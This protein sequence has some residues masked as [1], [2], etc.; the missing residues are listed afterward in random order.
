MADGAEDDEVPDLEDDDGDEDPACDGADG[1]SV[2][3]RSAG[4]IP[5]VA[6]SFS[7]GTLAPTQQAAPTSTKRKSGGSASG[8]K[9]A[10]KGQEEAEQDGEMPE[11]E[12]WKMISADPFLTK[13]ARE[14]NCAFSCLVGLLPNRVFIDKQK[15]GHQVKGATQG[16]RGFEVLG[17]SLIHI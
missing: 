17:L 10:K 14:L 6:P 4:F 13:I 11:T 8:G 9:K 15:V 2:G 5:P 7:F 12:V 1:T 16:I 3:G